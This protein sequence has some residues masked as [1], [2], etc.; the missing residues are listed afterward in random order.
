MLDA[1]Y[2]NKEL[3]VNKTW[4]QQSGYTLYIEEFNYSRLLTESLLYAIL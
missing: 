3:A 1:L 4:A 2:F